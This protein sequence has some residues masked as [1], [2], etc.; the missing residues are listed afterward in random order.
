MT[1]DDLRSRLIE[2]TGSPEAAD[3]LLPSVRRLEAWPAPEPSARETARLV[4]GLKLGADTLRPAGGWSP[5]NWWSLLRSQLWVLHPEIWAASAL[6]MALGAL[7]TLAYGMAASGGGPALPFV[8]IAPIVSAVGVAL[9]YGPSIDPALEIEMALPVPAGAY[10][11]ARLVLV[12]G[13]DLALGLAASLA[14]SVADAEISFWP[15]VGAWLAPMTFLSALAFLLATLTRDPGLGMLG[16][17]G[18]WAVQSVKAL[19][20]VSFG[21]PDLTAAGA[22]L[23]LWCLAVAMAACALWVGGR[24]EHWLRG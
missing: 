6:V 13:F 18:L 10:L 5:S 7:V 11:L 15:L 3:R 8:L 24:E 14:L 2:D 1:E 20:L 17:L 23:W 16:S 22:Q 21:W 12:Y 9:L 19:R 4:A